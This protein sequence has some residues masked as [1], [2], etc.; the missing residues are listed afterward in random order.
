MQSQL[1]AVGLLSPSSAT[2]QSGTDASRAPVPVDS[3]AYRE[4]GSHAGQ[5]GGSADGLQAAMFER[6][7]GLLGALALLGATA[8]PAA[9][10]AATGATAATAAT[11][12]AA[13]PAA[14]QGP[15]GEF[16]LGRVPGDVQKAGSSSASKP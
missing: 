7:E 13:Q 11:A 6:T 9:S 4:G 8:A 3:A 1:E 10:A 16:P 15:G 14:S 12:S 2:S 5:A